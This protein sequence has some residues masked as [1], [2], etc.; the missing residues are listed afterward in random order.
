MRQQRADRG[1]VGEHVVLEPRDQRARDVGRHG[2]HEIE[3]VRRQLGRQHR[4]RHDQR[5]A[6]HELAELAHQLLVGE[7][8]RAADVVDRARRLGDLRQ[9]G[10]VFEHV[11]ERDRL[12]ARAHPARR[13]HRRQV[14]DE[15]ADHLERRRAGAD[16]DAGAHLGDGHA[17]VAQ[18]V[19]GFAARGEVRRGLAG[20][21]QAAEI[22]DALHAGARRGIAEVLGGH[23]IEP[24]EVGPARHRMHEIVGD[25]DALQ[26]R[27]QRLGR[28]ARRPR[29]ARRPGQPRASSAARRRAA[30]RTVEPRAARH[31][32][33][34]V[35]T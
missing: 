15:V 17:A 10:Q 20:R 22:D 12:R 8:L 11:V 28:R 1:I 23:A 18:D 31:G 4:H 25:V 13:H 19:A 14:E 34:L 29:P 9:A 5:P 21:L 30:A 2:G 16:D 32:T 26:R 3:P 35:P 24:R 6:A 7:D 33:R 27:R